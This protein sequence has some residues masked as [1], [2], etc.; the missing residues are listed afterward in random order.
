M[1]H[2]LKERE[3]E[4]NED[5]ENKLRKVWREKEMEKKNY[6]LERGEEGKRRRKRKCMGMKRNKRWRVI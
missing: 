2:E 3:Q 5:E 4:G 6:E 1:L